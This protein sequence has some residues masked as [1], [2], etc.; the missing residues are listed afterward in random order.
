MN[1]KHNKRTEY[2][3]TFFDGSGR[4]FAF[5]CDRVGSVDL[6]TLYPEG[7]ES[8]QLCLSRSRGTIQNVEVQDSYILMDAR[9]IYVARVCSL[10]ED[11]V[12]A[13]YRP[14]IFEDGNYDLQG[15][16]LNEDD[17]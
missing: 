11:E 6:N 12:R 5:P 2:Q 3:L 13:K 7:R 15:E 16:T 14:E 4:G 17:Y 9:G 8:L 1:C 10:C